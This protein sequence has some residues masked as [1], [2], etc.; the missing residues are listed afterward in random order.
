MDLDLQNFAISYMDS[1]IKELL[2]PLTLGNSFS[3]NIGKILSEI[4]KVLSSRE[5]TYFTKIKAEP[6]KTVIYNRILNSYNNKKQLTFYFNLG[7][8]YHARVSGDLSFEPGLSE[9]L[10]IFQIKKFI[11]K[12]SEIFHFGVCFEIIIDNRCAE[13]ANKILIKNTI[14]YSDK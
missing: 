1:V 6:Y 7:G 3:S 2:K 9:L 8:G 5:F 12:L 10:A 14:N 4:F 11:D 13:L